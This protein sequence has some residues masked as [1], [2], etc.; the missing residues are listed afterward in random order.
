MSAAMVRNAT[1]QGY[2]AYD[3]GS[4]HNVL[5]AP[6]A[7]HMMFVTIFLSLAK[8]LRPAY[9]TFSHFSCE[10]HSTCIEEYC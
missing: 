9:K 3:G 6:S 7:I 5:C 10:S 2:A 8:P 1:S 4:P